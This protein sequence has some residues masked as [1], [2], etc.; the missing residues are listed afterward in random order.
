MKLKVNYPLSAFILVLCYSSTIKK[1]NDKRKSFRGTVL[2]CVYDYG[3]DICIR[4]ANGYTK[5]SRVI[6][7]S[8]VTVKATEGSK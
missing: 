5:E 3:R 6:V 2:F 7:G 4:A 1:K 8:N